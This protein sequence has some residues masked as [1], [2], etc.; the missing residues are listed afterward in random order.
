[1]AALY[2][3]LIGDKSEKRQYQSVLFSAPPLS[4]SQVPS[5]LAT[6]F[7]SIGSFMW[8]GC[9]LQGPES[10]ILTLFPLPSS[11]ISL[12]RTRG[13]AKMTPLQQSSVPL[14]AV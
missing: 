5:R 3:A 8:K 14:W 4:S 9:S 10:G 1:V 6:A 2:T 13:P 12:H 7:L 11:H